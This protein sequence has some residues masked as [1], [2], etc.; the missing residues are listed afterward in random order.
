MQTDWLEKLRASGPG[1]ALGCENCEYG[2]VAAPAII[3]AC[4]VSEQRAVAHI[5]GLIMYCDCRAGHMYRQ[6]NRRVA[7]TLD[8]YSRNSI[9]GYMAVASMPTIRFVDAS[10]PAPTPEPEPTP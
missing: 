1:W 2:L 7:V 8:E 10:Q 5:D 9:R 3:G 4:N 6:H